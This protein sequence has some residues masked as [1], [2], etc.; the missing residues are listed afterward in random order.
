MDILRILSYV[1]RLLDRI[2]VVSLLQPSPEAVALFDEVIVLSDGGNIIFTGPTEEACDYF[3]E[4]GYVQPDSMDNADYLLAVASSDRKHLFRPA[5][6]GEEVS[7]EHHTTQSFAKSFRTGRRSN[8]IVEGQQR[9][10][11][12]DWAVA[13]NDGGTT[14]DTDRFRKKYQNSFWFSVWLNMKRAFV[15]WRR[16]TQFIRASIIKNIAMGLSVGFVFLNTD[17]NSSFFGVLFQGNLF[18][19]LGAVSECSC[20][21]WDMTIPSLLIQCNLSCS[22]M[23]SA[24]GKVE[25]GRAHV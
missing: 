1:S 9:E 5:E 15:L 12:N 21:Y 2:S 16:D 25:I 4:L 24:P 18:I 11:E 3:R 20:L 19:M 22:Q 6:L 13:M 17:M 7:S 14:Q 8:L 10:W 23:T